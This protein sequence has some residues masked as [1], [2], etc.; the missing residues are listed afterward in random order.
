M[1]GFATGVAKRVALVPETT[2]GVSPVTG[3]KYLRRVSSDLTLNID[4]YESQEIL[5]SQQIEDARHGVHRPQ[6]TFS[7]QLSPG[8]FDDIFQSIM[9]STYT[10]GAVISTVTLALNTTAGTLTL[11]GGGL[12]AGGIKRE[13][14]IRISGAGSP[15]TAINGV[16]LR[17]NGLSDTVITTRDLPT[18]G[19]TTG[20]LTGVTITVVGKKLTMPATGQLYLSYSIEHWFS[21]VGISELFT[22]CRF[23]Q[24]AIAMP[25]TG[26]V[27]F[28]SQVL[29]QQ[30][31]TGTSQ[32]L[33]SPTGP[34]TSSALAAVNGS[35]S[36]NDVD[37]AII[38][39]L[40]L[41]IAPE[42][43]APA[44][45]GSNTVPWIFMGRMRVS[46]NFTALFMDETLS[47]SFINETEVTLAV[48]LTMGTG[49]SP[50]FMKFTL[51]RVKA[52]SDQKSDGS[53]SLIQSMSFTGLQNVADTTADL[54][55]LVIQDSLA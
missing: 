54:T 35:L 30:M 49:P 51:P 32:A 52:M 50:D 25:S 8:S 45:I 12:F 27:T 21:D 55:T 13:D 44:V 1:T 42:L 15:N 6:G 34:S 26:L 41:T 18:S 47:N 17:V 37:L 38:T 53:M 43:E 5:V 19:L 33:T 31:T 36:Y 16:N 9:R 4:S 10:T 11:S 46:G 24:T 14:V 23:G 7:G 22:G 28:N 3:S 39:G 40:N 29:G 48:N 20:S 2:F